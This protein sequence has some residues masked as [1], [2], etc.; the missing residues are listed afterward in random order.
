LLYFSN[1]FRE[2]HCVALSEES[3]MAIK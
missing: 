2:L 1:D 3:E